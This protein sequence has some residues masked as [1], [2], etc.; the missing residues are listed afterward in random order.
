MMSYTSGHSV[1]TYMYNDTDILTKAY[2][3]TWV[4]T[5]VVYSGSIFGENRGGD[6]LTRQSIRTCMHVHDLSSGVK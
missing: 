6:L 4:S 5:I 2:L 1:Y 3:E